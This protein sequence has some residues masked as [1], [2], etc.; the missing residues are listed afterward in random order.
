MKIIPLAAL[1][2]VLVGACAR[3][4]TLSPPPSLTSGA[5][6]G[7]VA[8]AHPAEYVEGT[9]Q[10]AGDTCGSHVCCSGAKQVFCCAVGE[11]CPVSGEAEACYW[12]H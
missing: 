6:P 1:A 5:P 3:S 12:M 11:R 4:A 9:S 7:A 8:R 10:C 2:L